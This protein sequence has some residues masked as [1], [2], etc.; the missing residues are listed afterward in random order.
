MSTLP[1][2]NIRNSLRVRT[3][4]CTCFTVASASPLDFSWDS[5][6]EAS[7]TISPENLFC[8]SLHNALIEGSWSDFKVS[9]L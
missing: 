7:G 9:L 5:L 2:L 3:R 4:P 6:G 1:N 8:T